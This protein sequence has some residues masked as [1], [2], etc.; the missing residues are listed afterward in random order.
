MVM[1]CGC[2]AGLCVVGLLLRSAAK[3]AHTYIPEKEQDTLC[4]FGVL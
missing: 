2:I 3:W 1:A 4:V